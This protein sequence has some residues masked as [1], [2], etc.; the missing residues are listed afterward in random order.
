[1]KQAKTQ[2]I[3]F[4]IMLSSK[5]YDPNKNIFFCLAVCLLLAKENFVIKR[6]F[7]FSV[8]NVYCSDNCWVDYKL[9]CTRIPLTFLKDVY[10]YINKIIF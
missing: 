5:S 8:F 9:K 1:M 3:H 6:I 10:F 4:L 2:Q 7:I